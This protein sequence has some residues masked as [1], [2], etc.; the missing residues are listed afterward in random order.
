MT[1]TLGALVRHIAVLSFVILAA[2]GGAWGCSGRE[3]DRES[4]GEPAA[5]ESVTRQA[6]DTGASIFELDLPLTD[7]EGRPATLADLGGE[8]TLAAMVYTTCTAVCPRIT[9]EML[10]I[11]RQLAG[12]GEEVHFVLFSLDPGR[13]TPAAMRQFARD[14]HLSERWRMLAA[15]EEGVRDLAAVLGVKY[16]PEADGEIAHSAL[17]VLIDREGIV[18]HRQVGLGQNPGGLIAAVRQAR[19]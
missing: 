1:G 8:V 17:I 15:S 3:S 19:G 9:E 7:Q 11:E 18:R 12:A 16:R 13:D 4:A 10:E 2:A 5:A 6:S 14:H